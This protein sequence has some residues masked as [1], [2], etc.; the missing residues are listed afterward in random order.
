L[1]TDDMS[2]TA[3]SQRFVVCDLVLLQDLP[4]EHSFHPGWVAVELVG[5]TSSLTS[6]A[7]D[8]EAAQASR[9]SQSHLTRDDA[10]GRYW[11]RTSDL[12]RVRAESPPGNAAECGL[13]SACRVA[14]VRHGAVWLA[15]SLAD[16][17]Q[18][19]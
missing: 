12:F 3:K 10:G 16:S 15:D 7:N 18:V 19:V 9:L 2:S 13:W 17:E 8:M 1:I 14:H 4:A 6:K 5:Q 11:I